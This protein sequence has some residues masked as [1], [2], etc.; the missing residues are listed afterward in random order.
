MG[1][2]WQKELEWEHQKKIMKKSSTSLCKMMRPT[3]NWSNSTLI[4]IHWSRTRTKPRLISAML[5]WST[6]RCRQ[7]YKRSSRLP[8][9]NNKLWIRNMMILKNQRIKKRWRLRLYLLKL[10]RVSRS[11]RT[12]MLWKLNNIKR[13]PLLSRNLKRRSPKM[14]KSLRLS[15]MNSQN[16]WKDHKLS[17]SIRIRSSQNLKKRKRLSLKSKNF[18][19]R[20][21]SG[22]PRTRLEMPRTKL[23]RLNQSWLNLMT[24][25]NH[26]R[27][28]WLD[29]N[30][31]GVQAIL[32]KMA[33]TK[34]SRKLMLWNWNK[35]SVRHKKLHM[36]W[37]KNQ[38][39]RNMR[40]LL[41]LLLLSN[42]N[43][44]LNSKNLMHKNLIELKRRRLHSKLNKKN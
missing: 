30:K 2:F 11:T 23:R 10:L 27:K 35:L 36:N 17:S 28:K 31:P 32:L 43:N 26:S 34:P 29:W 6:E 7:S 13:P 18:S 22:K 38:V 20:L 9:R 5:I 3:T 24:K 14:N 39:N 37:V 19:S 4:M 44:L 1:R 15:M 25:F 42:N 41:N 12:W 21:L 16:Q 8:R 40:R 33:S